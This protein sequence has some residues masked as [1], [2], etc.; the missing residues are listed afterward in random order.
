MERTKKIL[1]AFITA[2]FPDNSSYFGGVVFRE[3]L[4]NLLIIGVVE[5]I[6]QAELYFALRF[7]I[8]SLAFGYSCLPKNA[9]LGLQIFIPLLYGLLML[10][11]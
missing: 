11:L 5:D 8:G 4:L 2:L 1:C 6:S 7:F 3:V 9:L 10:L